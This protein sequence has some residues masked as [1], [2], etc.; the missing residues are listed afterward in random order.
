MVQRGCGGMEGCCM[1]EKKKS[2][3]DYAM[4]TSGEGA[5]MRLF[6]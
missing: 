5:N 3:V 4:A 6:G 1:G 2:R